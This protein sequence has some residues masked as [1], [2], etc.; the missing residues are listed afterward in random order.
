[1]VRIT[2]ILVRSIWLRFLFSL[3]FLLIIWTILFG[4]EIYSYSLVSETMPADAAIVLGAAT[5][6]ERPSPVFEERIKHA[7]DLYQQ[8]HVKFIIFTG[9]IDAGA[10]EAESIIASKYAVQHGVASGDMFCETISTNT[11]ENLLGA[12][13]IIQQQHIDRVLIVSDPLHMRRAM[14]MAQDLG[15]DAYS[16][17]TPTSRYISQQS[18]LDFLWGEVRYYATYLARR[19]FMVTST[20]GDRFHSC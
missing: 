11:Y 19:P 20:L 16:S 12:K 10:Q 2:R 5:W 18:Q 17:P 7:I 14:T 3:I 1:M 15:L 8:K 9:G 4:V 13:A 6:N